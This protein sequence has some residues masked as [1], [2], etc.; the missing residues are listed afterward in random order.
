MNDLV[1]QIV[2]TIRSL[3]S[4]GPVAA[5]EIAFLGLD[6]VRAKL[7]DDRWKRF[8]SAIHQLVE[9]VIR[10]I[11]GPND[12][13]FRLDEDQYLL[14]FSNCTEDV[15]EIRAATIGSRIGQSLFGKDGLD[16][17]K[18]ITAG[19]SADGI[20]ELISRSPREVV[21]DLKERAQRSKDLMA[22]DLP[23][24]AIEREAASSGT[25]LDRAA[26]RAKLLQSLHSAK[27]Q[28]VSFQF[29]PFWHAPS[30]RVATFQCSGFRQVGILGD[31][32]SG[33]SVLGDAPDHESIFQYDVDLI[34][35]SLLAMTRALRRGNKVHIVLSMHFETV[36]SSHGRQR[37]TEIL[38]VVPADLRSYITTL[39]H[40]VPNGV[41]QTRFGDIC[42]YL[43]PFCTNLNINIQ[44]DRPMAEYKNLFNRLQSV[45][46]QY[47]CVAMSGD[48]GRA[49]VH[50]MIRIVEIAQEFRI[51]GVIRKVQSASDAL[52]LVSG[53][54]EY[55]SG[56]LFGGPFEHLP[57]PYS[58]SVGDLEKI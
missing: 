32:E 21:E 44:S 3:K 58:F 42:T 1:R 6:D 7:G 56:G 54:F 28:P 19:R 33:Y 23:E 5:A 57:T 25:G 17:V 35:E 24:A 34:E 50:D 43:R 51:R 4:E 48:G 52:E 45:G 46:L 53:G 26:R 31:A 55:C 49:E 22:I 41:P 16:G 30:R 36:G 27:A 39:I 9:K 38:K 12:A 2:S 40:G 37:V 11:C 13:Y 15:A 14:I 29:T 10:E 20:E 8:G 47:F 18:V